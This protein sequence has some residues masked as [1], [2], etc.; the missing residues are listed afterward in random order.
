MN[1]CRYR[2]LSFAIECILKLIRNAL[3]KNITVS[4]TMKI[5]RT[6]I[7]LR[8]ERNMKRKEWLVITECTFS[9][10]PPQKKQVDT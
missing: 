4:E 8:I 7:I 5:L 3:K 2:Q 6:D 9:N 10:D 1:K